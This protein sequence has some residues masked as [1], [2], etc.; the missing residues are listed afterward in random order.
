MPK[1]KKAPDAAPEETVAP[2]AEQEETAA[3]S[4][5]DGLTFDR[6]VRLYRK[7]GVKID[8]LQAEYDAKLAALEAEQNV[9]KEAILDHMKTQNAKSIN[10]PYGTAILTKRTR[11]SISSDSWDSFKTFVIENDAVDLFEKRIA[12]ANMAQF[13]EQNPKNVPPGLNADSAYVVSV[14][15]PKSN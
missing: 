6:F 11:Y 15:K 8:E 3:P 5:Q 2:A 4:A 13:L 7:I 12:Q 9:F 14:R 1:A 10:T